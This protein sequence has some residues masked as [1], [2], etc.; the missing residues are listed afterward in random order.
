MDPGSNIGN[1]KESDIV[2]EISFKIAEVLESFGY[3]VVLTRENKESLCEGEFIKKE[4]TEKRINT[5]NSHNTIIVI[6]IHLNEFGLSEYRGGQV[7]YNDNNP[8]NKLL[9]N[10]IQKSLKMYLKNTDR[11]II[12]KENNY[13]LK[14][15]T[16]PACIVECGFMSNDQELSLLLDE[17]YQYRLA[18][19]I[20]YGI[21]SYLSEKNINNNY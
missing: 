2:L 7:F 19:S 14:R 13:L 6:S 18:M 4:D 10:H 17:K 1:I 11:S 3:N 5:I 9:A 16:C 21:N 8:A 12:K 20:L 15:I